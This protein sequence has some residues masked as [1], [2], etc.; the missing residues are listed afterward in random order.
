MKRYLLIF[1]IFL[2]ALCNSTKGEIMAAETKLDDGLYAKFIT[3]KGDI[4]I[5]LEFEN[6]PDS[7]FVDGHV[8]TGIQSPLVMATGMNSLL[9]TPMR[10]YRNSRLAITP[11]RGRHFPTQE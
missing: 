5:K 4:T 3:S 6:A 7:A 8:I 9:T 1:I 11:N 2:I 10:C